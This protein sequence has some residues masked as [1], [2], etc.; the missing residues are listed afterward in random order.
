MNTQPIRY[1]KRRRVERIGLGLPL[2]GRVGTTDVVILD[3]SLMGC[4]LEHASPMKVGLTTHLTFH[5]EEEPVTLDAEIV[6][7][8]LATFS[9]GHDAITVYHSGLRFIGSSNASAD[10]IRRLILHQVAD[11][12][13]AQ[14]A[15]ARGDIPR[16]MQR[17]QIFSPR[18]LLTADQAEV[19]KVFESTTGLPYMR[20]AR[21]R[22]YVRWTPSNGSWRTI[23]TRSPEQPEEG[24]TVWAY[25]DEDQLRELAEAWSNA[26]PEMRRLIRLCAELSLVVDD[27]IPPQKFQP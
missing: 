26:T 17:M 22:G 10:A 19:A 14:K 25:E 1:A 2:L 24:F 27:T 23:R 13:E 21:Q 16:Y 7:C 15:N 18:G 11:A 8:S 12:L 6:R 5:W 3:V 9:S 20:I 4:Q